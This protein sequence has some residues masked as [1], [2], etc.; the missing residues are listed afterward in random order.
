M[1]KNKSD[2]IEKMIPANMAQ[3]EHWELNRRSFLRTALLAGA[4]SQIAWFTSCS[5][6]LEVRNEFLTAEQSTILKSVLMIIFPDDGNGPS[7][8]D[9]NSFGYILWSLG[10]EYD[11]TQDKEFIING[12]DWTNEFAIENFNDNYY[13]LSESDKANVIA[14]I[15]EEKWGKNWMSVMVTL[16]LESLVLDPIYGGNKDEKGWEWLEHEA[17]SPRPTEGTRLESFVA[18][19]KPFAI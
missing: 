9:L 4:A 19:H 17:G 2:S 18:K 5:T 15:Q 11:P 1:K 7:A 6:Q 3:M 13:D 14:S 8:D 10:N 12:L 16:V